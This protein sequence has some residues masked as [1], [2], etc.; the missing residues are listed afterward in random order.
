M[1]IETYVQLLFVIIITHTT[2]L[3]TI[4]SASYKGNQW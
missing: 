2:V 3:S 1:T 4:V